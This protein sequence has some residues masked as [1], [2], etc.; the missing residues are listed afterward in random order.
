MQKIPSNEYMMSM[1]MADDSS[2]EEFLNNWDHRAVLYSKQ[3]K[4]LLSLLPSTTTR[5]GKSPSKAGKKKQSMW[6]SKGVKKARL[7]A[8]FNNNIDNINKSVKDAMMGEEVYSRLYKTMET[9]V[10]DL[11]AVCKILMEDLK[12]MT[13]Y[14][15]VNSNKI[16]DSF[17]YIEKNRS[18]LDE[19]LK[20][21]SGPVVGPSKVSKPSNS[22]ENNALKKQK[23]FSKSTLEDV[24]KGSG[25]RLV[26]KTPRKV[27][28]LSS[29]DSKAISSLNGGG[30]SRSSIGDKIV[31]KLDD[32]DS[33]RSSKPQ[34][35]KSSADLKQSPKLVDGR[36]GNITVKKTIGARLSVE[37]K[38]DSYRKNRLKRVSG[39]NLKRL[40]N[41]LGGGE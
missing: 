19:L 33:M 25:S 26:K 4:K 28:S 31:N 2:K 8:A 22:V 17:N 37:G 7:L 30:S 5:S 23:G 32:K 6:V 13:E 9:Q 16:A 21:V 15:R 24:E 38:R 11:K 3:E 14:L 40:R 34:G 39:L 10:I 29:V 12:N 18:L 35:G 1:P 36:G 41:S 20:N 27:K